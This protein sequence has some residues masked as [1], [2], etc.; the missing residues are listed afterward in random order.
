MVLS[1]TGS[2]SVSQILAEYRINTYI[3][4]Q[5]NPKPISFADFRH[6]KYGNA[7]L[8]KFRGASNM[9]F[10]DGVAPSHT[11]TENESFYTAGKKNNITIRVVI[12]ITGSERSNPTGG[13]IYEMGAS[14]R[15]LMMYIT[16]SNATQTSFGDISSGTTLFVQ[17]GNG[18]VAG[19]SVEVSFPIPNDWYRTFRFH[20]IVF[21][22]SVFPTISSAKG[23]TQN[24]AYLWIDG[25]LVD[26][27]LV[28]MGS[29]GTNPVCWGNDGGAFGGI[30][31]GSCIR[32]YSYGY[33]R[34]HSY[35]GDYKA[36][37]WTDKAISS[38][39]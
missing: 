31:G 34:N 1:S 12:G 20:E 9:D 11:H 33:L 25:E 39:Y 17:C 15:G 38:Y 28:D 36:E 14:G 24:R 6:F 2:I 13:V 3:L 7:N 16:H 4:L 37:V 8:G 23:G 35:Y 10:I 22:C 18:G 21:S 32:R 5:N 26:S 30:N 19:G 29:L 27:A